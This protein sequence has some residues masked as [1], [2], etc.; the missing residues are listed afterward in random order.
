MNPIKRGPV[1]QLGWNYVEAGLLSEG[2]D[3]LA[4]RNAEYVS[5]PPWRP[6]TRAEKRR[7]IK[8]RNR[9]DDWSTMLV[10]DG[11][12]PDL[13]WD[14]VF[15]GLNRIGNQTAAY[16]EFH[17]QRLPIGISHSTIISSD[18]G[19]DC[20]IHQVHYLSHYIVGNGAILFNIDEMLTTNYAKFGNGV[21]KDG[22]DESVRIW[23]EVANENAGRK[24]LPFDGLTPAD[25]YLWSRNRSNHNVLDR[26]EAM[27]DLIADSKR[28]HYGKVG[29]STVI[30]SCRIIKDVMFGEHAYVKGANKLKNLTIKSRAGA[31]TQIGEGVELVNGIIE[32]GCRIFY[33]VKA[34]R[35]CLRTNASLKYG[36][37]L[38]NSILGD[39][40]TISCC[41]VLNSI[42]YPA[43]EQHHNNSFLV[44][45]T[46]QGQSNIAAG[47]TI[48]SN[49][50]SRA[51]DGEI[52]AGRGFWPGLCVTLKHSSRFASF[53][54]IAKGNYPAELN[55][56]LPFTLV[57]NDDQNNTLQLRPG[58]WFQHN[59]YAL[60]RNSWKCG[61]RD[62]KLY[63]SQCFEYDYLAPDTVEELYR[64]VEILE[65]WAGGST[66]GDDCDP[67]LV[68]KRGKGLL[69]SRTLP[70]NIAVAPTGI[71][72]TSR[73]VV[74]L[75]I[76]EGYD[77]YLEMIHYYG[78][79][80]VADHVI[81][82][83]ISSLDELKQT[84]SGA[85]RARW[86]NLG[87]QLV[88]EGDYEDIIRRIEDG[89][90]SSWDSLHDEYRRLSE[91]YPVQ[92]AQHG[93]AALLSLHNIDVNTLDRDEWNCWLDRGLALQEQV[94]KRTRTSREK[95]YQNAFR[96]MMYGSEQEMNDVVGP[97]EKN[98]FIEELERQTAA[99]RQ[100]L[101]AIRF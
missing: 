38:I 32:I 24:I 50:N 75:R 7:L 20:A 47:A 36:A 2:T 62:L 44:A 27:T 52:F 90:I 16:L 15:H 96:T 3:E 58:Y 10:T 4:M 99:F 68:R 66:G 92:K 21:V 53:C 40:G 55:V 1:A 37:R 81:K 5:L 30:K 28:G 18:I 11:F 56:E 88:R 48:G 43:H 34:V 94:L 35:F 26:L 95:D 89:T 84:F 82:N 29:N 63:S 60:A 49:H 17:D 77:S 79:R 23:L 76:Q 83:D 6:L 100:T 45:A 93:F 64:G 41:E 70:Q 42:V 65:F 73:G 54:L 31:S 12:R 67:D 71:E 46:V 98:S 22:E 39:N 86:V 61:N 51:N 80:V 19:N 8:N 33:G 14:S 85:T 87:G 72:G 69:E 25:A 13:I 9:S 91:R 59:M 57:S 97:I 101:E 74:V 78:V